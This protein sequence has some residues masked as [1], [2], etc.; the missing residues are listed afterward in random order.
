[1]HNHVANQLSRPVPAEC[2]FG[3]GSVGGRTNPKPLSPCKL[4][5]VDPH[6][7][8]AP[9]LHYGRLQNA[10]SHPE[11]LP[12]LGLPDLAQQ[13]AG[14]WSKP[15]HNVHNGGFFL[16]PYCGGGGDYRLYESLRIRLKRS[17]K[18]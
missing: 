7:D 10:V 16:L 8:I 3:S 11:V 5:E 6:R 13:S 4:S 12:L 2:Y 1:M 17:P 14:G 15:L 9:L 18:P